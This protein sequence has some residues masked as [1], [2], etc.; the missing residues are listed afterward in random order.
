MKLLLVSG[1]ASFSTRDVWDGYL[2]EL[3]NC[4]REIEVVPYPLFT[5]LSVYSA[6][7]V[8]NDLVGRALDIR[9]GFDAV[10]FIDGLFFRDA[11][12]WVPITLSAQGL[13]TAVIPTDDPYEEIA[14]RAFALRF[15]N[16]RTCASAESIYL[17]VAAE[18]PQTPSEAAEQDI[19]VCFIGTVF[20]DRLPL[21]E[22][23]AAHCEQR[24]LR[25]ELRG[26]FFRQP[27]S[28]MNRTWT[29]VVP[30]TV[31]REDRLALYRRSRI[32]LNIFRA[33]CSAESASPRVYE[34]AALGYSALLTS[35]RKEVEE[36]FGDSV[37]FF[38]DETELAA[39]LD[40]AL[41]DGEDRQRRIR[42][43][44]AVVRSGHLYEHRAGILADALRDRAAAGIEDMLFPDDRQ[45]CFIFG[46]PRTG[47]TWLLQMLAG[48]DPVVVWDEPR[49]GWITTALSQYPAELK[50]SDAFF[51][52]DF[53][54]IWTSSI[55]QMF[56]DMARGRWPS[57]KP[58]DILVV[59]EVNSNE[60][61]PF[62]ADFFPRS[63]Y[64]LLLR[65]PFDVLDSLIDMQRP[66]SWNEGYWDE[67][68]ADW[69]E[70]AKI[71]H[72]AGSIVR[73]FRQSLLG[74]ERCAAG[75]RLCLRYENTLQ[76]PGSTLLAC[77]DFLGIR[78]AREKIE[79]V[80]AQRR[81]DGIT[82]PTGRNFPHRF[83]RAGI[84]KESGNFTELVSRIAEVELGALRFELG[85]VSNSRVAAAAI[86]DRLPSTPSA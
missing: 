83:G 28:L 71:R 36:I 63:K 77:A 56:L 17:P 76:D 13:L 9:N 22:A 57:A 18:L 47:S 45:I 26:H 73:S 84:W 59:K 70:E 64:I 54:E 25:F 78:I 11:R 46:A 50:R 74:Y 60:F 75:S 5:M 31:T 15:T 52:Q 10:V 69:P 21:I 7:A 65:D 66:G 34:T 41:I 81:F 85:Y 32:V 58:L 86:G 42:E 19:D 72:L 38:S 29:R 30:G 82:K 24:G 2:A 14:S 20:E 12:E 40:R 44:S 27:E 37:Y 48:L 61:A 55:R 67:D 8:C 3:R 51:S 79:S 4:G 23:L 33:H 35:R 68:Q 39:Q 80:A 49:F 53:A 16:E 6:E 62:Y 43:A 1:A